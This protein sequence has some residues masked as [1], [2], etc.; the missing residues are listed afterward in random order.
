VISLFIFVRDELLSLQVMVDKI[1]T[2]AIAIILTNT[3]SK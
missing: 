1:T 3:Y 2:C